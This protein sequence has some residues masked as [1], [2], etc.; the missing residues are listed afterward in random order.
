MA[1]RLAQIAVVLAIVAFWLHSMREAIEQAREAP[2]PEVRQGSPP[3]EALIARALD[4]DREQYL[5]IYQDGKRVGYSYTLV[6]PPLDG[7]T[8]V[9]RNEMDF[10]P[11]ILVSIPAHAQSE[12]QIGS[13][14]LI[15]RF[16]TEVRVASLVGEVVMSFEG[17]QDGKDVVVTARS[18]L[19]GPPRTQRIFRELAIFNGLSP[20]VG[21]P[22]LRVGEEWLI[23]GVDF[24]MLGSALDPG[25]IRTKNYVARIAREETLILEGRPQRTFVAEIGEEANDPLRRTARAWIA[26]DG[27]ILREEHRVL[28]WTFT[29]KREPAPRRR[30]WR[31]FR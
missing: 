9:I 17:V 16:K 24:S 27:R 2:P 30:A 19:G 10:T 20:F 11:D 31:P 3:Y 6:S 13:D 21:V 1:L 23:Q 28:N 18:S 26:P 7:R 5:G 29:F 22:E 8:T 12:I 25:A 15:E 4:N 14:Y